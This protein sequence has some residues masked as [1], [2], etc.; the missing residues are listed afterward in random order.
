M[1]FCKPPPPPFFFHD[2]ESKMKNR[3]KT[4]AQHCKEFYPIWSRRCGEMA[5]DGE[6]K[7]RL[8]ARLSGSML[9]ETLSPHEIHYS[10]ATAKGI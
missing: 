7:R 2:R 5:S 10:N 8:Y 9:T 3:E 6:T 4:S 1:E